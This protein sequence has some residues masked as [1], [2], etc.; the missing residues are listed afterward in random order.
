MIT[1]KST[2]IPATLLLLA[3]LVWGQTNVYW[4]NNVARADAVRAASQLRM[5]MWEEH[6]SKQLATNGLKNTVG[7]GAAVGWNRY[8]G[9][10]DGS[11][12]VLDYSARYIATTG[13]WGGNGILQRAWIESNSVLVTQIALTN[14]P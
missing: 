7:I 8:Y 13:H 10:S 9:L 11:S 14:A 1:M 12:L 2:V 5:G 4:S 3:A 6:A